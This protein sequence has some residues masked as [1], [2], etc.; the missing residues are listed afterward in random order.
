MFSAS[1]TEERSSRNLHPI[2]EQS[3]ITAAVR[4]VGEHER[5]RLRYIYALTDSHLLDD[6]VE[7]G[8]QRRG[9]AHPQ[10]MAW[11][12]DAGVDGQDAGSRVAAARSS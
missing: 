11:N 3:G 6:I 10:N 4:E 9:V 8:P 12:A 5:I 2:S 7:I 1:R